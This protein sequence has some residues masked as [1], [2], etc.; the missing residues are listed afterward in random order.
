VTV[1][2]LIEVL[3]G[4]QTIVFDG[5]LLGEASSEFG[6]RGERRER[7]SVIQIFKTSDGKYVVAKIGK[8]RVVHSSPR[9]K[10]LR[11][12]I[13]PPTL[14]DAS[15]VDALSFA[16]CSVCRPVLTIDDLY[17]EREHSSAVV[18]DDPTGAVAACYSRD[19]N[20]IW[21]LSHNAEDAVRAA[22][23]SD[24]DLESAYLRFDATRLGRR[25]S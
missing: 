14:V 22:M 2:P 1:V 24:Q 10:V 7:W 25:R 8:S 12:N 6:F 9:C 23:E 11:S 19:R 5:D 15:Q 21:F 13:D 17:L 4:D 3:N 16:P 20:G 18:A